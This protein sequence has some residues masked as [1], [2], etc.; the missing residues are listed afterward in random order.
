MSTVKTMD[1][2]VVIAPHREY[3]KVKG[4]DVLDTCLVQRPRAEPT[5]LWLKAFVI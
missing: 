1:N 3:H 5:K 2:S 4:A